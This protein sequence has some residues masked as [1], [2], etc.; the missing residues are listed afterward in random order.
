MRSHTFH[1]DVLLRDAQTELSDPQPWAP[2]GPSTEEVALVVASC[3]RLDYSFNGPDPEEVVRNTLQRDGAVY[4]TPPPV[5]TSLSMKRGVSDQGETGL[6]GS[7]PEKRNSDPDSYG[8]TPRAK[9]RDHL[10]PHIPILGTNDRHGHEDLVF[11]SP[12]ERTP[13]GELGQTLLFSHSSSYPTI[14]SPRLSDTSSARASRAPSRERSATTPG[15]PSRPSPLA[16][17][18]PLSLSS[19]PLP[20]TDDENETETGGSPISRNTGVSTPTSPTARKSRSPSRD[21]VSSSS[22]LGPTRLLS[23]SSSE[24]SRATSRRGS[25][26]LSAVLP[27]STSRSSSSSGLTSPTQPLLTPPSHSDPSPT[28][29]EPHSFS[30]GS[31]PT[32]SSTPQHPSGRALE[33]LQQ[34]NSRLRDLIGLSVWTREQ[35][36]RHVERLHR[37]RII[38]TG[39]EAERQSLVSFLLTFPGVSPTKYFLH[40]F[41]IIGYETTSGA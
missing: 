19:I 4:R 34:E 32:P 13:S 16:Q 33:I 10:H 12:V 8:T 38:I 11:D 41:S 20:E 39:E 23:H 18:S 2:M 5:L 17:P 30:L 21:L 22:S 28:L 9:L 27:F 35:V 40:R 25:T 29:L 7:G 1:P 36:K 14:S 37:D 31:S 24:P 6:A 15:P 26:N 3:I